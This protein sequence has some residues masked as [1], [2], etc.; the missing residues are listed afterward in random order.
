MA[1]QTTYE[2]GTYEKI[3]FLTNKDSVKVPEGKTV[4]F[5]VKLSAQ[6]SS[7]VLATLSRGSGDEHITVKSGPELTFT[8]DNWNEFQTVTL[9]AA[10]DDDVVNG[11]ATILIHD[12]DSVIP[13]KTI[14]AKK[15]DNDK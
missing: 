1:E 8:P 3:S 2:S 5:K 14:P 15:D 10:K 12:S 7:D 6:P 11:E 4:T 13:D 9:E